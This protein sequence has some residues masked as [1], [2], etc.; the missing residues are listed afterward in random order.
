[1]AG[2]KF[3]LTL[4]CL[5]VI[6]P[7]ISCQRRPFWRL[8]TRRQKPTL[9]PIE[10]NPEFYRKLQQIP[11]KNETARK[12]ITNIL[13][14]LPGGKRGIKLEDVVIVI[15]GSGSIGTCGFTN[16]KK[17]M[18]SLIKYKQSGINAKYAMVTFANDAKVN[19]NFL[20][21][22]KAVAKISG[23]KHFGGGT[24]TQAGLGAAFKLFK[25]GKKTGGS[26][27]F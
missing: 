1:M 25:K 27:H 20:S 4:L 23:I 17:A 12:V 14:I 2:I 21:H 11:P 16:G 18:Q 10:I 8:P 24:N 5:V 22:D 15:D 7:N 19:F 6:L 3:K 26:W 13:R 9:P